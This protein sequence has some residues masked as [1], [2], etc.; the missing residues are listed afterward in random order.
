MPNNIGRPVSNKNK[1]PAKVW[2]QWS[3]QA[4]RV[5]NRVYDEM[6]PSRQSLFQHSRV[7]PLPV[8]YWNTTR[9]NAAFIA[10]VAVDK[11]GR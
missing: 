9:W 4:R 1:V 3:N 5:F 6:R 10:A 2:R 11:T 7:I 8:K